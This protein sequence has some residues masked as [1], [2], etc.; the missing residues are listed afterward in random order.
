MV[1]LSEPRSETWESHSSKT[2]THS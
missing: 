1:E 2:I